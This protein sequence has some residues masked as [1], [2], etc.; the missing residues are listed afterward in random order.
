LPPIVGH[1][2][3]SAG[4][5]SNDGSVKSVERSIDLLFVLAER[6]VT[7]TEVSNRTGLSKSTALRLLSTLAHGG[8]IIKDP[9]SGN[10]QLGPGC[11]KLGHGFMTGQGGFEALAREPLHLLWEETGETVTVHVRTG[12]QRVC[13]D[14]IPSA[15]SVRYVAE[16]GASS[17]VYLG[18]AGRV[19]LAFLP[20]AELDVLI[21]GVRLVAPATGAVM[22][23]ASYRKELDAVRRRGY[24]MSESERILGGAAISVPIYKSGGVLASLSILGP[25]ARLTRKA[26]L[27]AL[28]RLNETAAELSKALLRTAPEAF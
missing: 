17:P 14:E 7:L 6:P 19:L 15:H 28:P 8:L 2:R 26:R 12:R 16:V 22:D 18:S 5:T 10:Y 13:V 27:A 24:A 11:L 9:L 20:P 4:S 21:G 23:D 3:R 25:S 1:L